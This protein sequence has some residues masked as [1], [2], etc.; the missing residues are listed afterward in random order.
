MHIS[1]AA[2]SLSTLLTLFPISLTLADEKADLGYLKCASAV[3]KTTH[4]PECTSSYKL[5][6]Y[7]QAA[8]PASSRATPSPSSSAIASSTA[9]RVSAFQLPPET[10]EI[11]ARFGV[12][13]DEIPRYLCDD[14][15]VPVSPRRGSMPMGRVERPHPEDTGDGDSFDG[16]EEASN[17]EVKRAMPLEGPRLLIPENE[18]I[19]TPLP[20]PPTS[21]DDV[22]NEG[23]GDNDQK[24][25]QDTG[26][27][28]VL[29]EM[30]HA[31]YEVVTVTKTEPQCSCAKTDTA[32]ET[33]TADS[34]SSPEPEE[35][36]SGA[37]H[38]TEVA[39]ATPAA[40]SELDTEAESESELKSTDASSSVRVALSPVGTL[41]TPTGVDAEREE[42]G[43]NE[44]AG[45]MFKG[46]AVRMTFSQSV[47]VLLSLVAG[48]VLL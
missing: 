32:T 10:E 22:D 21:D 9:D 33:E 3:I 40:D 44:P 46:G 28:R 34:E 29:D 15:A 7:C 24:Q 39:V 8:A 20:A 35:R 48:I 16:V 41:A 43:E 19:D 18:P 2:F 36:T 47:G 27:D 11:C 6:C 5:D 38:G 1:N 4:F 14:D 12:P 13:R 26:E 25:D 42:L 17:S 45:E 31:V 23:A 30:G 37:L